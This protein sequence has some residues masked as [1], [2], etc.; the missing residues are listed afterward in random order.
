MR[1]IG[2]KYKARA[3][4]EFD[5]KAVRPTADRVK[6]SLFNILFLKIRGAR[7][8]DL[9]SGSGALGLECLSRE[10]AEVVFNDLAKDSVELLKKNMRTLKI[11]PNGEN[12]KIYNFDFK[13][14]LGAVSGQFDLIFI[15]PPY[16]FDYGREALLTI[17]EK[18]LLSEEGIAIFE[19]DRKMDEPILGLEK[20]DER[21]YGKTWLS[22]FKKA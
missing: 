14:C 3:L 5:G 12:N 6:E 20:Y 2:G 11:A 21:K 9:F 18:G 7:V 17:A 22:F 19:R 15:D 16:A 4:A 1:I 8:L 10:A 13:T